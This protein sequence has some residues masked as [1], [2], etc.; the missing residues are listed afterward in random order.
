MPQFANTNWHNA[1]NFYGD[2]KDLESATLEDV[3]KFFG[4]YY[5]PNNAALVVVGDFDPAPARDLIKKYFGGIP[6]GP[7]PKFPD[8]AEPRQE[9]EKQSSRP[10]RLATGPAL[11]FAYHMPPRNTPEYWA[12]GLLDQLLLQGDDSLLRQKLVKEKGYTGAVEGGINLLGNMYDYDGPMLWMA[13]LFHDAAT[14]PEQVMESV[15]QV[16][17]PLR[18]KP[19]DAKAVAKALVKLRSDYYS[20]QE[21]F[22]GFGRADLLASLALFDDDPS[23]INGIEA[24][25]RKVTPDLIRKTAEEYLRRGNRTVLTI[26]PQPAPADGKQTS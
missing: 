11:A 16:I 26:Q 22:G 8:L 14:K 19:L 20:T 13:S 7:P 3:K 23:R 17:E 25:F 5:A 2:L 15:D 6:A 21:Q 10:D 18:T 24:Q 12:M 9:K 1:H 4:L